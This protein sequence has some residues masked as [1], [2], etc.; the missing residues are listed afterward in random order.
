[1]LNIVLEDRY[2]SFRSFKMARMKLENLYD[3][4]SVVYNDIYLN[5]IPRILLYII[6]LILV[7]RS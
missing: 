6:D 5:F 2:V 7:C 4:K 3:V 1:M